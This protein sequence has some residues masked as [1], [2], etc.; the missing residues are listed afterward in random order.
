MDNKIVYIDESKS[1][2]MCNDDV[3]F[4][5]RLINLFT[6]KNLKILSLVLVCL[7]AIILFC[8]VG[9][10]DELDNEYDFK[11]S[12]INCTNLSYINKTIK[13]KKLLIWRY[14]GKKN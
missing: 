10:D 12:I 13:R 9:S 7:V 11:F 6:K 3:S 14:C 5:C 2:N 8:K 4:K 1:N